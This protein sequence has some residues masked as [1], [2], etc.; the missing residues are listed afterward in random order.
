MIEKPRWC[1]QDVLFSSLI[2]NQFY[3]VELIKLLANSQDNPHLFGRWGLSIINI[4]CLATKF[5]EGNVF[6]HVC[7]SV[8]LSTGRGPMW[9]LPMIHWTTPIAT[10]CQP[11][12][13]AKTGDLLEL[14]ILQVKWVPK[15]RKT[16]SGKKRQ[17][18]SKAVGVQKWA[19]LHSLPT[20]LLQKT[21]RN[22]N[23]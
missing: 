16:L 4:Y 7:L 2:P 14:G 1:N 20:P 18:K 11:H 9:L 6:S 15:Y 19:P 17:Q 10:R 8:C 5:W 22:H 21:Y 12:L 23:P 3:R 13:M